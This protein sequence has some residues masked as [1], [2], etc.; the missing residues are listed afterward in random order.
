MRKQFNLQDWLKDKSQKVETRDGRPSRIL[1]WDRR[2]ERTLV[3]LVQQ[4]NGFDDVLFY[5]ESGLAD[6]VG[7]ESDE[8]LFI[9]TPEPELSEFEMAIA[10]YRPQS[11][12]QET[13]Q[14]IAAEL[15]ELATEELKKTFVLLHKDDYQT[16]FD[17]G[18]TEA[19]EKYKQSWFNEGKIAGRF[20][21]LT[22]DEKY[23]QGVHDGKEEALKDLLRWKKT[24]KDMRVINKCIVDW[25]GEII[26]SNFIPK[27]TYYIPI[28]ELEKLPKKDEGHE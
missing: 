10:K 27:N 14:R 26:A 28:S 15:L 24:E 16:A 11:D 12:S 25:N 23:Q 7:L 4:P 13:I 21:G 3:V 18:K 6:G 17:L 2:G 20:E 9:V 8:D 1:C 22:E 19:I 5:Y